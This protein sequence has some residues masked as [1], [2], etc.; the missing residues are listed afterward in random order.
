MQLSRFLAKNRIIDLEGN[1]LRSVFGELLDTCAIEEVQD[2][3]E[4][5]LKDLID[6]EQNMSTYLGD[7]IV[8]PNIR[9][10]MKRR[11]LL[12][13]GRI[14]EGINHENMEEYKEV[15]LVFLLIASQNERNYLNVLAALAR[16]FQEK[17]IAG[18]GLMEQSLEEFQNN[19]LQAFGAGQQS[20]QTKATK[21]NRFMMKE[22]QRLAKGMNCN[23]LM[24]FNDVFS[25]NVYLDQPVSE[26]KR[27]LISN[28]GV[29]TNARQQ[30]DE[31]ITVGSFS[32]SRLSQLRSAVLIG[33]TRGV[34]K[35]ND[36][37]CCL[38]G[39]PKSNEFDTLVIIDV[40]KE[41]KS[42]LS[43][44]AKLLPQN[45]K[46]EILERVFTIATELALEGREGK[47]VG[48]LFVVGD[49]QSIKP[50]TKPLVL[51]PFY[52][53]KDEDRNV[54]NPF[55]DETVK[56]FSSVDG[57]FIIRGDGVIESAGTLLHTP[58]IAPVL[59]SGLGSRHSAAAAISQASDCIAIVVSSSTGQVTVFRNGE[60]L[61]LVE[62]VQ[63]RED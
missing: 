57:A 19:V 6:R 12:A 35:F 42:V 14:P 46:P 62:R 23:W 52:G 21:G 56:E 43:R 22:A 3:K 29:D 5:I 34:I 58:E 8:F 50:F 26:I 10:E 27:V 1:D 44:D 2:K 31:V 53:Y 45:V 39:R 37:I 16:V 60:M 11:Y 30:F 47:P 28:T 33:L 59:P 24:V 49:V 38:S 63:L 25:T 20:K 7:G 51:N 15:R 41:F 40:E 32:S 36:L 54:L 17:L 48:C 61:P 18:Q 55:M 4:K 9:V 13:V